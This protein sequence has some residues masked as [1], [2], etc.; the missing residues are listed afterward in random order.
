MSLVR[1]GRER[2]RTRRWPRSS[3]GRWRRR[4]TRPTGRSVRWPGRAG[5]RTRRSGGYGR[6]SACS[7]LGD[8]QALQRSAVRGQGPRHRWALSVP[9]D[10]ALVLCVDEKSHS[11]HSIAHSRSCRC[12]GHARRLLQASD[13]ALAALDVDGP[14]HRQVLQ[15]PHFLKEID[16]RRGWTSTSSWTTRH[17]QDRG[18]Q[19]VAGAASAL[20][21]PLHADVGVLDQPGRTL[22]RRTDAQAAAAR[23]APLDPNSKPTSAP[24]STS[25]TKTPNPSS[26][27][28][29]PN[30]SPP[31]NASVSESRKTCHEL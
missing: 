22:V 8:L 7:R 11:R 4:P 23:C 13:L 3:S 21:H 1:D 26:G 14:R 6:P 2:S 20:A 28:N 27:P 12:A 30:S 10:R 25:T 31:S 17:S 18:G 5:C 16:R 9:P 24:S 19:G 15:T 29:P